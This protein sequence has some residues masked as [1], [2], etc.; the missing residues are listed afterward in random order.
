VSEIVHASGCRHERLSG[1]A[2]LRVPACRNAEESL[3]DMR[4]GSSTPRRNRLASHTATLALLA[5][6]FLPIASPAQALSDPTAPLPRSERVAGSSGVAR[7]APTWQLQSIMIGTDRRIAVING[8]VARV[9]MQVDG[10]TV[11][12]IDPASVLVDAG[13]RRL[14]LRLFDAAPA[15]EDSRGTP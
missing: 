1:D 14:R 9:G 10:A 11:L 5:L 7:Q 13:G 12:T 3:R 15:T 6:L 8:E 2:D 4:A